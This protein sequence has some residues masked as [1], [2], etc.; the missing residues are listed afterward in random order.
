M[1]TSLQSLS[2]EEMARQ[3]GLPD[4]DI[5]LAVAERI[6]T[7]NGPL[8]DDTLRR[9][10]LRAGHRVLE[11]G[12]G[13]GHLTPGLMALAP[14]LRYV[15]VDISQTMVEEAQRFNRSLVDAG[16]ARFEL[17]DAAR[18]P[19]PDASFDRAFAVNVIY[20]WP[21]Q[22]AALREIRRVLQ[23]GGRCLIAS[24]TPE[25]AADTNFMTEAN[26]FRIPDRM[27]LEALHREAGFRE[28][29]I[30]VYEEVV[31]R[32]NGEPWTRLFHMALAT[33]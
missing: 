33:A 4:G 2:P 7:V 16:H 24:A 17:A 12:F 21:D 18:L 25:T 30:G 3:L 29:E 11:L 9:L 26:G 22:E 27:Q 19:F 13:N 32:P 23:P 8:T 6:N 10:D 5:G 28:V 14:D 1:S 20:F 31:T 15:G